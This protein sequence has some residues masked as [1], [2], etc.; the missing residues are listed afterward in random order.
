[1]STRPRT[2]L[3]GRQWLILSQISSLSQ[4]VQNIS[5]SQP[6]L[7]P[8]TSCRKKGFPVGS[9]RSHVKFWNTTLS[10][11]LYQLTTSIRGQQSRKGEKLPMPHSIKI[12]SAS[13]LRNFNLEPRS[14]L[15]ITGRGGWR[16]GGENPHKDPPALTSL[17]TK[18][19][20]SVP[21]PGVKSEE[22]GKIQPSGK[23]SFLFIHNHP[24][25]IWAPDSSDFL[26]QRPQE[27]IKAGVW[28][29]PADQ[30][31]TCYGQKAMAHEFVHPPMCEGPWRTVKERCQS[32][33][34]GMRSYSLIVYPWFPL[35]LSSVLWGSWKSQESSKQVCFFFQFNQYNLLIY[36]ATLSQNRI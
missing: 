17:S 23:P 29:R 20:S 30:W 5:A 10:L 2:S 33:T 1:M 36:Q 35:A 19:V 15:D 18:C 27:K 6:L 24:C 28:R 34:R 31:A 25:V 13:W 22:P 32:S 26:A 8:N 12:Q 16:E 21:E 9:D 14:L 3:P 7:Q 4:N 11:P